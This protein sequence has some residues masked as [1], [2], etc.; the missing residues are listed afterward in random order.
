MLHLTKSLREVMWPSAVVLSSW[1]LAYPDILFD[2][3][4]IELGAGCGLTGLVASRIVAEYAKQNQKD[5]ETMD[6]RLKECA[7][8]NNGPTGIVLQNINKQKII[9]TDFNSKVLQN[10]D[11]NIEL[12]EL[13][14]V[15]TTMQLDF[16]AQ[17]GDNF[18]GSWATEFGE[19]QPPVDLILAADVICK[20]DDSIA[21]SKTIYD[22]LKPGAEAII[23]SANSQHR[24]GVDI[25]SKEC[26]NRGLKV[27]TIDIADLCEG[28]L[29]PKTEE[30]ED[31]CGIR[32][33]SGFVDGMSLTM[34]RVLKPSD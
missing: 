4:I 3:H 10:L 29:L 27:T 31:P 25:F 34:F 15:A 14:S 19:K 17:A 33:T 32:K 8:E 7:T 12:N 26:K 9:L 28:K 21:A 23:V 22:V 11:R 13:N 6:K 18:K 24:F 1:L 5:Y 20:P 2:K 16:Y 30:N